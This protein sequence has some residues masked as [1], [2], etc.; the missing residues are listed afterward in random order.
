M[1]AEPRRL[2]SNRDLNLHSSDKQKS[3]KETRGKGGRKKEKDWLG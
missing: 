1:C 2:I 3:G